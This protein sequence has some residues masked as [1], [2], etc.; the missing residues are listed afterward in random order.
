MKGNVKGLDFSLN[1]MPYIN[2][3]DECL[4]IKIVVLR[5]KW[6]IF[7]VFLLLMKLLVVKLYYIRCLLY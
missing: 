3:L 1:P 4:T 5:Q 6:L 2:I 7:K